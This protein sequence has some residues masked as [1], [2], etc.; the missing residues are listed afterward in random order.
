[1]PVDVFYEN[2]EHIAALKA[3]PYIEYFDSKRQ[4]EV[5]MLQ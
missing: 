3:L 4:V 2:E 1:M 5:R